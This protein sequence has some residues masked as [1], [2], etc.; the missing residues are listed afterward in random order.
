MTAASKFLTLQE[1]V[2]D[3][4]DLYLSFKIPLLMC[5]CDTACRFRHM[6]CRAPDVA[7]ELWRNFAGC[8]EEPTLGKPPMKVVQISIIFEF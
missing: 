6:D 2:Q 3:A 5:L 4:A 1:S 8:F 7:K